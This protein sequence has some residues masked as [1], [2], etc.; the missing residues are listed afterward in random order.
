MRNSRTVPVIIAVGERIDRPAGP[1]QSLEPVA[2][3]AAALQACEADANVALL[4]H[5]TSIS[6][7]GLVS[8]RYADPVSS[9]CANL[10]ISPQEQVN[11]SM[12]GETPV[13]LIH[14]AAV[15]I[16]RGEALVAA[17]VGGEAT[18]A[19]AQARKV[20]AE[21]SWTPMVD[22]KDAV[23]FPSTNIAKSPVAETLGVT[24]PSQIYPF[25]EVATQS[26]WGQN[27]AEANA[28]SAALWARYARV[29]ANNP[30]AWIRTAPDA[31]SIGTVTADNRMISW[32]YSKLMVANPSVNQS[33]AIIVTSLEKALE[34]GIA[35]DRFIHIWGGASACE[36]EDYLQRDRYDRSTAQTAVLNRAVE[37]VGG[38]A[39]NFD[40][41][42]LY[43]CFPVVP[44]MALRTLGFNGD[45]PEPTVAGGLTFFGGP[46]NNYMGHAVAAMA[47]KLR[48][49]PSQIGLLYGQGGYVNKHHALVVSTAPP[50]ESLALDYSVQ[51]I[52][53]GARDPTPPLVDDYVGPAIIETYTVTYARDGAPLQGIVIG[54]TPAGARLMAR[55]PPDDQETLTQL[56]DANRSAV[57]A[58]GNVR[59]DAFG[60]PVWTSGSQI[61]ERPRSGCMVEREGHLTIVTINRPEAMNALDPNTNAELAEVFDDFAADP[62][63]WVAI[64]T[65]AG[66]RAFS[67]GNDLKETARRMTRGEPLET[68]K[69]GYGG[70]TERF[71]LDKPVIAAVNGLAMGGGFEVALACDLI[72]A[73]DTAVFALPEPK[74]GL[75]ALAGGLHRL[76]RQIGLKRAMGMILTARRVDAAEGHALGFVHEVVPADELMAA[77][78][79]LA[80]TILTLSPM[81]LRA[82]KQTVQRGLDE[83][84]LAEAYAA[85]DRYPAVKALFRSKDSREGPLAF[86]QKRQPKWTGK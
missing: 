47:R 39:H 73:A 62:D 49:H 64:I 2:L 58:D 75:A 22:H 69:A 40:H 34:L 60:K 80:E 10:G 12:G 19:R 68:P 81:S 82:S 9:L 24:D 29:A 5:I 18:H 14:E 17:V 36:P 23:R 55:V 54:R 30:S 31:E 84:T 48:A 85:Q 76:P 50:P 25:Y 59:I 74:V 27:P 15:R 28:D 72:V 63:Q 43:S 33:A 8:W 71:D 32:P 38:D 6:L 41:L 46:L 37:I 53:E 45:G 52:A 83:P 78:R 4:Q 61:R 21:L 7:V 79:K 11:A 35:E 3:M 16:A 66:D 67:A 13:R 77:A 26:A 44:K 56:T 86:A 65:G 1:M 20:K 42:E 70:L 57:G 51:A